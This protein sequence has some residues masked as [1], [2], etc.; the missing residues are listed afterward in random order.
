MATLING[1]VGLQAAVAFNADVAPTYLR[2]VGFAAPATIVRTGAGDYTLTLNEGINLQTE[3]QVQA[4]IIGATPGM[5]AVE[6]LTTTTAR[7]RTLNAA[8]AA[9]DL[10][11][12]LRVERVA[13][14]T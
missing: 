3:A 12:W 13:I 9:T 5:I 2:N 11:F 4:T 8:G 6:V 7:I 1:V 14:G 10:D